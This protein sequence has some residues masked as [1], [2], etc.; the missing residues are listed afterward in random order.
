M[1]KVAAIKPSQKPKTF[2]ALRDLTGRFL[3]LSL[4]RTHNIVVNRDFGYAI[5]VGAQPRSDRCRSG[6][7]FIDMTN[8]AFP[9]SPGCAWQDGYV[10]EYGPPP[11]PA[12]E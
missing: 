4:G 1:R 2:D 12:F 3:G 5:A 7:I 10:H 8:P 6:L 9:T 11:P